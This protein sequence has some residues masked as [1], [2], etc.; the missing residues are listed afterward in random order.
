M[1][2]GTNREKGHIC[3]EHWAKGYQ[4][5]TEDL[6][7]IIAPGSQILKMEKKRENILKK[8]LKDTSPKLKKYLKNLERKLTIANSNKL[9]S[10]RNAP[11]QRPPI[12]SIPKRTRTTSKNQLV[13]KFS[14]TVNQLEKLHANINSENNKVKQ[15]QNEIRKLKFIIQTKECQIRKLT[16]KN[17]KLETDYE[18]TNAD[19]FSYIK[20]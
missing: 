16:E 18:N 12:T 19:N 5:N 2:T 3:A 11:K 4:E 15:L 9:K 6:P 20:T 1:T 7:D 10:P 14:A 13:K 17:K 8:I